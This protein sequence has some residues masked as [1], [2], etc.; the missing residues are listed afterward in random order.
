MDITLPKKANWLFTVLTVLL[1]SFIA[2]FIFSGTASADTSTTANSQTTVVNSNVGTNSTTT[3]SSVQSTSTNPSSSTSQATVDKKATSSSDNSN[4]SEVSDVTEP[5]TSNANQQVS[6]SSATSSETKP[7]NNTAVTT[8]SQG[9][10]MNSSSNS[11]VKST[12]TSTPQP[13][14]SM[15]K[16]LVSTQ[17]NSVSVSGLD[18]NS[19]VI[20][21]D[22]GNVVSNSSTLSAY[23]SYVVNYNWSIPDG[24]NIKSGDTTTV[25]LPSNVKFNTDTSFPVTNSVG[26]TI[27]TFTASQD[28]QSGLLTFSNYF[29]N[30]TINR[31]GTLSFNVSGTQTSTGDNNRDWLSNKI[32]WWTNSNMVDGH[33]ASATW[34]IAFNPNNQ[35]LSKVVLVDTIGA[36]Q[37]FNNDIVA[38]TGSYDDNGKFNSNGTITPVVSINGQVVTMTFTNVTQAVNL[39]Y[40][41]TITGINSGNIYTNGVSYSGTGTNGEGNA[42]VNTSNNTAKLTFGGTGN[43]DG[44]IGSVTLTKENADGSVKLAGAVFK[45]V[46]ANGS[47]VESNLVTDA[48]GNITVNNLGAG[49]YQFIE[50]SAP[51][52]YILNNNPI[53]FTISNSNVN[54]TVSA[55][56]TAIAKTNI[57]VVKTWDGVPTNV[58]TPAITVVLNANGQP[59]GQS[60]TLDSSNNYQASFTGLDQTD[61]NGNP[62]NYTVTE[63][64]PAGYTSSTAGA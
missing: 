61:S 8:T 41:T 48:N 1:A 3:S 6:S 22:Q 57:K 12:A 55:V 49:S 51:T 4:K 2:L 25:T 56:N 28:A 14:L 31:S 18:A 17:S 39:T 27:G 29:E 19:A 44:T 26:D 60:L 37:T 7:S 58:K 45:L 30:N 23:N 53:N 5:A 10:A 47:L 11:N 59:T 21:D 24:S 33:P 54:A 16:A 36:N 32:G 13:K 46:D 15:A 9:A 64:I 42:E 63:N 50:T 35:T 43:G 34:N 40:T 52:G 20:K 62:I 38:N